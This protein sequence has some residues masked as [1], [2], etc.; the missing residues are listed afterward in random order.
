MLRT[1]SVN[2]FHE[3][4][5]D[6]LLRNKVRGIY[7]EFDIGAVV[8]EDRTA[9]E[10]VETFRYQIVQALYLA[11]DM[12]VDLDSLE[13]KEVRFQGLKFVGDCL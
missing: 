9:T 2:Q 11:A 3:D 12:R 13:F 5:F 4:K 6:N 10:M 7:V 8:P 1:V